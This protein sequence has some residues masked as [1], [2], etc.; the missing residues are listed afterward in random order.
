MSRTEEAARPVGSR[1]PA[2]AWLRA[3]ELT[4]P[5]LYDRIQ[6]CQVRL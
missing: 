5:M 2:K 3:F 4:A 6:V 1:S